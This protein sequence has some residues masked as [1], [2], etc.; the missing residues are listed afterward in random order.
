MFSIDLELIT[1]FFRESSWSGPIIFILVILAIWFFFT[2]CSG[3][4]GRNPSGPGGYGGGGGGPDD[5]H[6]P[7]SRGPPPPYG[8]TPGTNDNSGK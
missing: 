4:S 7:D 1:G 8:W 2:T 6:M 3:N 5:P